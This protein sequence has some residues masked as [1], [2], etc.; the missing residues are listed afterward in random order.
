MSKVCPD[1]GDDYVTISPRQSEY[2]SGKTFRVPFT[3]ICLTIYHDL[4]TAIWDCPNC[5]KERRD[6]RD[7]DIFDAGRES[8]YKQLDDRG[9]L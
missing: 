2:V 7:R 5:I 9:E 4:P 3:D 8:V 1:C 6:E